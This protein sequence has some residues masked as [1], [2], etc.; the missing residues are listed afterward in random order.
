MASQANM[1]HAWRVQRR[2]AIRTIRGY[3]TISGEAACLLA[4]MTPLHLMAVER[5]TTYQIA[6]SIRRGELSPEGE[7]VEVLRHQ[8]RRDTLVRWREEIASANSDRPIVRALLPVLEE[9]VHTPD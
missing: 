4:G 9:W 7:E 6:C 1:R 5:A 2:L 8:A 3:R